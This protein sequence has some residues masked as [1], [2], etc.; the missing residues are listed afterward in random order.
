MIRSIRV[1]NFTPIGSVILFALLGTFLMQSEFLK[2]LQRCVFLL[3]VVLFVVSTASITDPDDQ[4]PCFCF[5]TLLFC[6][7]EGFT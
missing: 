6:F 5:W 7:C 1:G 2:P 4:F 3:L